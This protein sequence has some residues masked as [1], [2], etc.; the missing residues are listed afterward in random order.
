MGLLH[1][2]K[3]N[4]MNTALE[5]FSEKGFD[6]TTISEIIEKTELSKG[7]VYH[8]F[9]SKEEIA[10]TAIQGFMMEVQEGCE[11]FI[12]TDMPA[13][14]KLQRIV[15]LKEEVGRGK[16]KALIEMLSNP[17]DLMV[18]HRINVANQKYFLPMMVKIIEQGKKEGAFKVNDPFTTAY[19]I[20][21]LQESIFLLPAKTLKDTKKLQV[22][23]N[24]SA[25]AIAKLLGIN[26]KD[27]K[28]NFKID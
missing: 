11:K 9:K 26:A 16:E 13:L 2:T 21:G 4:I 10:D 8:H 17:G 5:L 28:V 22:Y 18:R 23:I 1:P 12:N 7:A 20:A 6:N 3:E 15:T 25:S 27:L 19:L 14:E 24:E